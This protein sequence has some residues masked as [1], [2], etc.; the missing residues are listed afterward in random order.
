MK[1]WVYLTYYG[2]IYI[3][4]FQIPFLLIAYFNNFIELTFRFSN[5]SRLKFN[6]SLNTFIMI[7]FFNVQQV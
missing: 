2:Q 3:Y 6:S 7:Q 5:E 4:L 1:K